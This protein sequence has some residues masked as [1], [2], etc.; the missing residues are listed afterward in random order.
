MAAPRTEKKRIG[1]PK[2]LINSGVMWTESSV[3]G[4]GISSAC[5][6]CRNR[7]SR[8]SRQKLQPEFWFWGGLWSPQSYPS[9]GARASPRGATTSTASAKKWF[10]TRW[11]ERESPGSEVGGNRR[12]GHQEARLTPIGLIRL[13][14]LIENHRSDEHLRPLTHSGPDVLAEVLTLL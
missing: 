11:Y 13:S 10:G 14:I 2:C 7:P 3:S 6:H 9:P 8:K 4:S 12:A 5:N 1:G